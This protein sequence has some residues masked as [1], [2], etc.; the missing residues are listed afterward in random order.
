MAEMD[1]ELL[2]SMFSR[3]CQ[4]L[5]QA[6]TPELTFSHFLQTIVTTDD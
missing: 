1:L 4:L 3:I 2:V 5:G 6:Q